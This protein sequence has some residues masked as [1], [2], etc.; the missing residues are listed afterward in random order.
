[1]AFT[2]GFYNSKG[3]D[4]KYNADQMG[5][6]FDGILNDG[7]FDNVGNI[8]ATVPGEGLQVLV[9]SGR[10]WFNKTWSYNDAAYPIYLERPDVAVPR[11]DAIVLEVDRRETHRRNRIGYIVGIPDSTPKKPTLT[12]SDLIHQ[13]P[14]AYVTVR[15][16][17]ES[18]LHSDIEIRVG[19]SDCPFVT[20]ILQTA[21]I[22]DLFAAWNEQFTTWFEGVKSQLEGDV[23]ANLLKEIQKNKD[24]IDKLNGKLD[25]ISAYVTVYDMMQVG[26]VITTVKNAIDGRFILTNGAN[27]YRDSWPE[28]ETFFP[29]DI[30][31][32]WVSNQNITSSATAS[33]Y[34]PGKNNIGMLYDKDNN[35]YII[36]YAIVPD[37]TRFSIHI[38]YSTN[39][40]SWTTKQIYTNNGTG[41][42]SNF[43]F[44]DITKSNNTY[45]ITGSFCRYN[46][47]T[48]EGMFVLYSTDYKGTWALKKIM[49]SYAIPRPT[50][51][52]TYNG[53]CVVG[54]NISMSGGSPVYYMYSNGGP[55]T[56]WTEVR[57][58]FPDENSS[59]KMF[60]AIDGRTIAS[61]VQNKDAPTH[62]MCGS[63]RLVNDSYTYFIYGSLS[64]PTVHIVGKDSTNM[65]YYQAQEIEWHKGYFYFA[66]TIGRRINIYKFTDYTKFNI[67][68]S[69]TYESYVTLVNNLDATSNEAANP[70]SSVSKLCFYMDE[71]YV[72]VNKFVNYNNSI[73]H[74]LYKYDISGTK[75]NYLDSYE[76]GTR[77]IYYGNNVSRITNVIRTPSM[78]YALES[79]V[80]ES[81]HYN[82]TKLE[83]H[84]VDFGTFQIPSITANRSKVFIK[85]KSKL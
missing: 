83:Q 51:I 63:A 11:I 60:E 33:G 59:D 74:T 18:I 65:A 80:T 21:N 1:M 64:S 46:A 22:D 52:G 38:A 69:S 39:L 6:L 24:A 71:L 36:A 57:V 67:D 66:V 61:I 56:K 27:L 47:S 77:T 76:I 70:K 68:Y 9:K 40:K 43:T 50:C 54:Y 13:H 45:I 78:L 42:E 7:V 10:A 26:D 31:S 8:F 29:A 82:N 37:N 79:K 48:T 73:T 81:T 14:L 55:D 12:N 62:V 85:G 20:G 84:Y 17:T 30:K 72:V 34:F 41:R 75:I 44:G 16:G 25:N 15:A 58:S 49:E 53:S 23:A 2:Y 28:L 19:Q 32:G 35:V 4:R 3:G 5:N